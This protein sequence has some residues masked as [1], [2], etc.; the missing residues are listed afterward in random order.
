M[1]NYCKIPI[2]GYVWANTKG[3]WR[4]SYNP[5]M[6]IWTF[7]WNTFLNYLVIDC[8]WNQNYF[9][10]MNTWQNML[11][12]SMHFIQ[13]PRNYHFERSVYVL[14]ELPH[15]AKI[16]N[17]ITIIMFFG[18]ALLYRPS[19]ITGGMNTIYD[20]M[21]KQME[22][23]NFDTLSRYIKE[24]CKFNNGQFK[25]YCLDWGL[26]TRKNELCAKTKWLLTAVWKINCGYHF[27]KDT[28]LC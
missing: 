17:C 7:M 21:G 12:Y 28:F 22:S 4:L 20:L 11:K 26:K 5:N 1:T 24:I 15:L 3:I 6:I 18:F 8:I 14:Y 10:F 13:E 23:G 27:S 25:P 9:W 19:C 2:L 16:A